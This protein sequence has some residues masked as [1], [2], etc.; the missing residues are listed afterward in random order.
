LLEAPIVVTLVAERDGD[1][2]AITGA[3]R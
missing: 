1:V 3:S 2:I